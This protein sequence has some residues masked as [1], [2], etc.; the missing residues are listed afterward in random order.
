M[1]IKKLIASV[2]IALGAWMS[3][4]ATQAQTYYDFSTTVSGANKHSIATV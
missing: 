3:V 1:N 4:G 2:V